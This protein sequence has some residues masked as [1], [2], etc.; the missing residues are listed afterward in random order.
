MPGDLS[1]DQR[2]T[3]GAISWAGLAGL[4]ISW[5][6]RPGEGRRVHAGADRVPSGVG[7]PDS[8]DQSLLGAQGFL[9]Q[10]GIYVDEP[11]LGAAEQSQRAVAGHVAPGQEVG[12][13][14]GQVAM[15]HAL[16]PRVVGGNGPALF[17]PVKVDQRVGDVR[18][19]QE[20]CRLVGDGRLPD[21][22]RSG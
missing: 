18:L 3:P 10:A 14:A 19:A 2:G 12:P 17:D 6:C 8:C 15:A 16:V 7:Q 11:E 4:R 9:D 1:G 5:F 21:P 20:P 13:H 22:D